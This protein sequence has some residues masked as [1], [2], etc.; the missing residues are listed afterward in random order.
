MRFGLVFTLI[1]A[2]IIAIMSMIMHYSNPMVD[3]IVMTMIGF[4]WSGKV[5]RDFARRNK[6]H[7]SSA[8]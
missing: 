8:D 5:G 1:F 7:E 6:K 2:A 3:N 4:A